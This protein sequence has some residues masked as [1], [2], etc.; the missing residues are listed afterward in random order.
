MGPAYV[1]IEWSYLEEESAP[2]PPYRWGRNANKLN[3]WRQ[4]GAARARATALASGSHFRLARHHAE[5]ICPPQMSL[6]LLAEVVTTPELG[7]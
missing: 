6:F 3:C 2:K 4:G 7:V 5:F 1:C